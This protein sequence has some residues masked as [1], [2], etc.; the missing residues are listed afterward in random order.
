[1]F[2]LVLEEHQVYQNN[3]GGLMHKSKLAPS[4]MRFMASLHVTSETRIFVRSSKV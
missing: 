2:Y 4:V 3:Y 1:M